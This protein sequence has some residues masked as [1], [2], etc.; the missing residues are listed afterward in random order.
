MIPKN[1]REI[2]FCGICEHLNKGGGEYPCCDCTTKSLFEFRKKN[3]EA[4]NL[5]IQ[6]KEHHVHFEEVAEWKPEN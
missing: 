6:T 2:K 5:H 4:W 1:A 3:K